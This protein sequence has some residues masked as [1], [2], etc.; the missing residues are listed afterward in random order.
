M[1][2]FYG[3]VIVLIIVIARFYNLGIT[4]YGLN[5]DEASYGYDAY[6][7]LKTGKDQWGNTFPV[8]LLSFGDSKPAGLAYVISP[9]I[10][11]FDLGTLAIR[12]PSAISGMY[13]IGIFYLIL[14]H[15]S[16]TK[17]NLFLVVVFALS[18]WSYG[19][20]RLFYEPNIALAF[21]MTGW[22]NLLYYTEFKKSKYLYIASILLA[23]SGYF[24]V[25]YRLISVLTLSY[26]LLSQ[27]HKSNQAQWVRSS[28]TTF[29]LFSLI[30]L[31]LINS[32]SAEGGTRLRQELKLR[33]TDHQ[34]YIDD[35]R[36]M[37]YLAADK[38]PIVT[39]LCY[40]IWNKPVVKLQR[41]GETILT[42]FSP[43]YLFQNS[44]QLDIIPK[45]YGAYQNVLA[46]FY[47]LGLI[48]I[49]GSIIHKDKN[50]QQYKILFSS[51]LIFQLPGVIIEQPLVHRNLAAIFMVAL[52]ISL[53]WHYISQYLHQHSKIL[54]S[55]II[56][57]TLCAVII[58]QSISFL[59]YYHS[60]YVNT[61]PN[62]WRYGI[63][64]V[65]R[66]V[67]ANEAEYESI[68]FD[69]FEDPILYYAFYAKIAPQS[70][71]EHAIMNPPN[72]E[73]WM[74][75]ASYKKF[76]AKNIGIRNALCAYEKNP[77]KTLYLS[78]PESEFSKYRS[79]Y[80]G[81]ITQV[82]VLYEVYDLSK[83]NSEYKKDYPHHLTFCK[84]N[85]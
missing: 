34:M 33:T 77:I 38:N 42:N 41:M 64:E 57:V 84:V 58:F 29:L 7:L 40:L 48:A 69:G 18:P 15:L 3:L 50:S 81:D 5:I 27:Y 14:Q 76:T 74:H 22:L 71:Q 78:P 37:C 43:H 72:A 52:I 79:Y 51:F 31:P 73:G 20:S 4:P 24:Y 49:L 39:K 17:W 67:I 66:Y 63:D 13:L 21:F 35:N 65:F 32:I 6:S 1:K 9:L 12:L 2:W 30:S 55:L 85:Q 8:S 62:V 23:I 10:P 47:L 60:V 19:I 61:Q 25:A 28:L 68:T 46:P 26:I 56:Q 45:G 11:I 80:V 70:F 54:I 75:Y 36:S 44:Y 82:H 53:G 59:A 83:L 16:R